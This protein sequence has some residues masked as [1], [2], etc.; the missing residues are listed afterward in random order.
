MFLLIIEREFIFLRHIQQVTNWGKSLI[1]M[2][3]IQQLLVDDSNE[4]SAFWAANTL[5]FWMLME[6][7]D[8]TG[9]GFLS[10]TEG[11]I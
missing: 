4:N 2:F 6:G 5:L 10:I 1:V 3:H 9:C 7:H 11:E 8:S